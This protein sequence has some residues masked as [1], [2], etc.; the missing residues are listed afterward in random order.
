MLA[1]CLTRSPTGLT[2]ATAAASSQGQDS[3]GAQDGAG[4]GV[5]SRPPW[6]NDLLMFVHASLS[7]GT[8]CPPRK[9]GEVIVAHAGISLRAYLLRLL[10]RTPPHGFDTHISW[11]KSA[12]FS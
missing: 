2:G 10:T 4:P 3:G 9:S 12:S 5:C 8:Y 6:K 11:K 7:L 1:L